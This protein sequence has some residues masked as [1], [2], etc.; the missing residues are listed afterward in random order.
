LTLGKY[1]SHMIVTVSEYRIRIMGLQHKLSRS[2]C[3]VTSPEGI[4]LT[5]TI[6]LNDFLVFCPS[7]LDIRKM[8][9]L[10]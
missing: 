2:S 4:F 6:S 1:L 7:Q 9:S 8:Y 3:W 5:F 10:F